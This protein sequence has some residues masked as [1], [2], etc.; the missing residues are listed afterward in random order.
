MT[1][2]RSRFGLLLALLPAARAQDADP[3]VLATLRPGHPRLLLTDERLAEIQ[4]QRPIDP[5]LAKVLADCLARAERAL[6]EPPLQ[7]QKTGPRLLAV[8]HHCLN[9]VYDLGLAY[10]L[11]REPRFAQAVQDLLLTVCA[12]PDWNPT[13]FLDTAEMAHAV[14]I[15][16][17][18]CYAALTP[19]VRATVRAGLIRLGLVPG[20]AA[21]SGSRTAWWLRSPFNWNLVCN[22]GLVIATLALAETDPI[23][24]QR[25]VP[26]ARRS[27]PLALATY[28]PDGAWPEGPGYWD[29]ATRYAVFALAALDT[30]L[31][32]RAGL[33]DNDGLRRTGWFALA[34]TGPTGLLAAYA[35][36]NERA[37]RKGWPTLFWLAERFGQPGLAAAERAWLR[38]HEAEPLHAL[39]YRPEPGGPGAAVAPTPLSRQFRGLVPLAFLR[40]GAGPDA[41][42]VVLKAGDNTVAH[43]H[44]DLGGFECD[45]LGVRWARDLGSDDYDLPGYFDARP[46]GRRWNWYRTGS[47]SHSVLRVD[48]ADQAVTARAR[49]QTFRPGPATPAAVVAIDGAFPGVVTRQQRGLR[50]IGDGTALL[51]QDELTLTRAAT[52]IWAMTTD[53]EVQL[54][55]GTAQLSLAGRQL[56]A[57]L[58]A[59]DPIAWTVAPATQVPPQ[60]PNAG[61]RQLLA[62]THAGPGPVRIAVLL[63]PIRPGAASRPALPTLESLDHW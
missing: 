33:G 35:D 19:E 32:V 22:G 44:L 4:Q 47:H 18:W 14:A 50:L 13:H 3:A 39:W 49:L 61:V 6:R 27:L 41:L 20:T 28:D 30:A 2:G 10:R 57:R 23:Y 60:N 43:G 11:T 34:A 38:D 58:L 8:S 53:A 15:G 12:F 48:D 7:Y 25:I 59:P 17:D 54:Q 31:G 24:A 26:A 9:R 42:W 46:G 51:V 1:T 52:V 37:A 55:D 21:V 56:V 62:T 5:L 29:Y 45:A 63:A 40:G 16:Y 36:I